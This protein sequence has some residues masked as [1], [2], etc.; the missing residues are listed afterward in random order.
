MEADKKWKS[1]SVMGRFVNTGNCEQELTHQQNGDL[2]LIQNHAPQNN[3]A[4]NIVDL[5]A[6]TTYNL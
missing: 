1:A 3:I 6:H 5:N 4:R 2:A